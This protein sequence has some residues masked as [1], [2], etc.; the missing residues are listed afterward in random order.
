M[1]V[2]KM[3]QSIFISETASCKIVV[4]DSLLLIAT[5]F[6]MESEILS[7]MSK[8]KI[9]SHLICYFAL[10]PSQKRPNFDDFSIFSNE[11]MNPNGT[12]SD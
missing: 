4:A 7:N 10:Q 8:P 1:G 3:G 9:F 11:H 5:T 2:I 12:N 6:I